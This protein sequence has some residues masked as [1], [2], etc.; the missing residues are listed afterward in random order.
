MPEIGPAFLQDSYYGRSPALE[1]VYGMI[2]DVPGGYSIYTGNPFVW[3]RLNAS[4]EWAVGRVDPPLRTSPRVD[5]GLLGAALAFALIP[6]TIVLAVGRK[7]YGSSST[8]QSG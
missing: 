6:V 1:S 4:T 8:R 3:P 7:S 5:L 2:G